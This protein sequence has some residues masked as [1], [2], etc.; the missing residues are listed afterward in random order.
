[1]K[2]LSLDQSTLK[3]GVSVF[4]DKTLQ[5]HFLIDLSKEKKIS[6][7]ER[8]EKMMNEIKKLIEE[9]NPDVVIF[10]DVSF[11]NN[12]QTLVKLSR[13]QGSIIQNCLDKNI[14]YKILTPNEWRCCLKFQL[15]K[16]CRRDFLKRQARLYVKIHYNEEM[17]EDEADSVCIG[18][19][20]LELNKNFV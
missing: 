6:N 9:E 7:D 11:Q 5:N 14:N 8:L 2:I 15:G 4:K 18:S 1:M 12:V 3:T 16:G 17:S 10:E 19:A 13:L 20:F